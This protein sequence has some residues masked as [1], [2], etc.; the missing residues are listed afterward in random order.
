MREKMVRVERSGTVAA[1]PELAWSLLSS[2]G[3][4]SLFPGVSFAFDVAASPAGA[5]HLLFCISAAADGL[6]GDVLE[7][8]DQVPGHVICVQARSRQP[9]GRVRSRCPP[10]RRGAA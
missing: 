10:S 9:A 7:V 8:C 3:A 4:W 1:A 2:A 6:G 5:G